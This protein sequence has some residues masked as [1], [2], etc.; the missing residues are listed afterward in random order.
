GLAALEHEVAARERIPAAILR[1]Q[2]ES[3]ARIAPDAARR[4]AVSRALTA[5]LRSL[6]RP[7]DL[8]A[9]REGE[10]IIAM[11]PS[12]S[13]EQAEAL[14]RRLVE[15]A[16]RLEVDGARAPVHAGLSIGLAHSQADLPC[17]FETLLA[18][19]QDGVEVALG[20]GGER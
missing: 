10:Q 11:L 12:A 13:C 19:A 9:W 16:R 2:V 20:S 17:W 1:I 5:L 18:V 4:E 3:L 14:A 8:F 7:G 15:G 6:P